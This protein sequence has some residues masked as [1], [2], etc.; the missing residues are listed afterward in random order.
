MAALALSVTVETSVLTSLRCLF[1]GNQGQCEQAGG[2]SESGISA[3]YVDANVRSAHDSC[4]AGA[5]QGDAKQALKLLEP[6]SAYD[7]ACPQAFLNT[8]PTLYPVYVRGQAYLKAPGKDKRLP[9][10][11]RR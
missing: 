11:F 9:Q 7:L 1:A 2:R 5:R 6:T 4:H 8:E 10:N 3:G